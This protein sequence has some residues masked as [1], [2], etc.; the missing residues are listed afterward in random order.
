MCVLYFTHKNRPD[1]T[2]N[3]NFAGFLL[4]LIDARL[5]PVTFNSL[6]DVEHASDM[7]HSTLNF[8]SMEV[9]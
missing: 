6:H 8:L 5:N 7:T 2:Y 9:K 3:L 4:K 1:K